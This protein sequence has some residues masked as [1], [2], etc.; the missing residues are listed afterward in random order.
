MLLP[1][2][3]WCIDL[4]QTVIL[5]DIASPA[6]DTAHLVKC[7]PIKQEAPSSNLNIHVKKQRTVVASSTGDTETRFLESQSRQSEKPSSHVELGD[8]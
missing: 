7:L 5:K 3:F 4:L 1:Q 2:S 6:E 8:F